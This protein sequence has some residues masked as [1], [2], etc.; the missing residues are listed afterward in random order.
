MSFFYLNAVK[1]DIPVHLLEEIALERL[2]YLQ[3]ILKN[4]QITYYNEYLIEGSIYDNIG[5]FVLCIVCIMCK[6]TEFT[7]FLLKS[8]QELF[9]R[10][11]S[12]ISAYDLRSFSK[13]L[14]RSIRKQEST[15]VYIDALKKLCEH[16]TVKDLAQ[17][18]CSPTHSVQCSVHKI[19]LP[20]RHC[21]SFIAKRQVE[22]Q[23]GIA[24]ITCGRW[25]QFLILLFCTNLNERLFKTKI[26]ALEIDPRISEL[27]LKVKREIRPL[28]SSKYDTNVLLSKNVDSVSSLFPPCMLNLHQCLRKKHRLSHM[29]RFHYSLFLKDIGMPI[30][31]AV[32]FWRSEYRQSPNGNH[33]CCHNWEKDEKKYL[34]GIRHMYG[35]EGCRK[36]YNSVNC[37]IIQGVDN[38]CSEGGCPFKVFESSRMA[39]ILDI[40]DHDPVLTQINELKR[41]Q[42]YSS[43]CILYLR[44]KCMN[45]S[46]NCDIQNASFNFTPVKYYN[47]NA[48]NKNNCL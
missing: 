9:R 26:G 1:G 24:F 46:A 33:S 42:Q 31:E 48:L 30:D 20:F 8:E 3:A 4:D 36:N 6:E 34:Y 17:H 38:A 7:R 45:T 39:Q 18:V 11:L 2:R 10:R 12:A 29:Q 5:H 37:R 22:L 19:S 32:D 41:K 40:S 23:N 28:L 25:K 27:M 35:L 43:A 15:P 13:K 47:I 16:M 14:L 21:L 44:N